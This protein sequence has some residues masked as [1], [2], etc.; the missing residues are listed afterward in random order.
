LMVKRLQWRRTYESGMISA[1][2]YGCQIA[3]KDS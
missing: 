3:G 1:Q 2:R